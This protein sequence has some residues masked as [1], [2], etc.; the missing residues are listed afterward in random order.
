MRSWSKW[1]VNDPI[2]IRKSPLKSNMNNNHRLIVVFRNPCARCG[3]FFE[4]G[5]R[6]FKKRTATGLGYRTETRQEVGG[7]PQNGL[8]GGGDSSS[9]FAGDDGSMFFEPN[10]NGNAGG[11]LHLVANGFHTVFQHLDLIGE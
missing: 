5:R 4:T 2:Y 1:F 3:R 11:F 10:D 7:A 9:K 8:Q 6:S